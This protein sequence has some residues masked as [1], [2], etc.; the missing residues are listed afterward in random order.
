[1]TTTKQFDFINRLTSVVTTTNATIVVK[2]APLYNLAGQRTNV[3]L[4]DNSYWVYQYDSLGQVTS[5]KRYWSGGAPVAGQQF[6]Y[7]F[8]TIG[9]RG[10]SKS[11]GDTNGANLHT[12]YYTANSVNQYTALQVPGYLG[13]SGTATNST[14]TIVFVGTQQAS[15]HDDYFYGETYYDNSS[16]PIL[17]GS[18]RQS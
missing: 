5:G 17:K 1:M 16:G 6:E 10:S 12:T 7:A 9:N 15:R 18:V 4:A 8:D 11:G 14:N 2:S 3:A 13:V